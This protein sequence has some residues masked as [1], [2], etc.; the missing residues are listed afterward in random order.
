MILQTS[1]HART[2][3][4]DAHDTFWCVATHGNIEGVTLEKKQQEILNTGSGTIPVRGQRARAFR[5]P[6]CIT[7]GH[8][9]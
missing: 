5:S 6:A 8:V 2:H 4:Y 7:R 3:M 9:L 1:T